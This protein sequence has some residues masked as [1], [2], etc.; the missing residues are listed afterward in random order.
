MK[1]KGWIIAG[2]LAL[3]IVLG[4]VLGVVCWQN[5]YKLNADEIDRISL[6]P[7][8][9]TASVNLEAEDAERFIELFNAAKYA[10][11]ANGEGTTPEWLVRVYCNDG[12][13]YKIS[14]FSKTSGRIQVSYYDPSGGMEAWFYVESLELMD[15]VL[16]MVSKY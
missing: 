15:F 3:C 9:F 12:S 4:I 10:G 7:D 2:A 5:R 14:D 8:P 6:L 1:K 13:C 11:E 16:E